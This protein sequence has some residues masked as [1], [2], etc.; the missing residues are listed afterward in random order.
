MR[1]SLNPL[2]PEQMHDSAHKQAMNNDRRKLLSAMAGLMVALPLMPNLLWSQDIQDAL[3]TSEDSVFEE[4]MKLSAELTAWSGLDRESGKKILQK[5]RNEPWGSEHLQR[6][7]NKFSTGQEAGSEKKEIF[8]SM[9]EGELW[10]AGHLLTTWV[11]GMYFHESGN[12][13]ISYDHALMF[14][15]FRDIYPEPNYC[16]SEFGYWQKAPFQS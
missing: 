11:T 6:V 9:D 15:A 14:D 3:A 13:V 12:A 4:F 2:M 1:K 7:I 10:F 8:E 16:Q 5:M